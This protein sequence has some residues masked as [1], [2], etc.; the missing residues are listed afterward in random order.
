MST[1]SGRNRFNVLLTRA[2]KTI[3]F[4]SS[5]RSNDFKLTDNES[6]ELIR[7]WF[8]FLESIEEIELPTFPM[9]LKP[10]VS[11][12]QLSFEN[13]HETVQNAVELKTIYAVL[14]TRGWKIQFI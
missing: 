6:I 5:V 13:I 10:Q 8:V 3:S 9:H 1:I 11:E 14:K 2:R 7:K 12:D 4:Y